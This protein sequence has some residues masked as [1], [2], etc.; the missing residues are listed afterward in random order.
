LGEAIKQLRGRGLRL[1]EALVQGWHKLYG[2]TSAEGG[3]R[4]A[5]QDE[6]QV[7]FADAKYMLVSCA[8]FTTYLLQLTDQAGLKLSG[9]ST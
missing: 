2:Y 7:D 1:H 9:R 5:M 8:A 6:P 4:H 3:I